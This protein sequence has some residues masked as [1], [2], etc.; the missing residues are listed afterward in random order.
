[1]SP[2]VALGEGRVPCFRQVHN[3]FDETK[4]KGKVGV[5]KGVHTTLILRSHA[6]TYKRQRPARLSRLRPCSLL[7]PPAPRHGHNPLLAPLRGFP[8]AASVLSR[9]PSKLRSFASLPFPVLRFLLPHPSLRNSGQASV[10]TG[11]CLTNHVP[12]TEQRGERVFPLRP[13]Q[14]RFSND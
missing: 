2:A 13:P 11:R 14:G 7:L 5:L 8:P 6:V 12:G 4:D 3:E 10:V 1:M 9:S